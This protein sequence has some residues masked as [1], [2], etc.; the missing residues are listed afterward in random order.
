[1]PLTAREATAA[2]GDRARARAREAFADY[3]A[4]VE[5]GLPAVSAAAE[6]KE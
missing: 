1:M 2:A 3:R 5:A 6:G 4:R